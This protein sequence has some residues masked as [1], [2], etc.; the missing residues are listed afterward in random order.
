MLAILSYAGIMLYYSCLFRLLLFGQQ[1]F[2]VCFLYHTI[3]YCILCHPM[4]LSIII[5]L[6]IKYSY[7]YYYY[8]YYFYC[9]NFSSSF[10][11]MQQ[12]Y[13]QCILF[14]FF[15][16]YV[17]FF[18]REIWQFTFMQISDTIVIFPSCNLCHFYIDIWFLGIAKICIFIKISLE[19]KTCISLNQLLEQKQN[20][21]PSYIYIYIYFINMQNTHKISEKKLNLNIKYFWKLLFD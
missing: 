9:Y 4:T 19:M 13:C 3:S 18:G 6:H 2:P 1:S 10:S 16:V 8:L 20:N 17:Y 14:V 12:W 11:Y 5:I 7:H 15:H 21:F